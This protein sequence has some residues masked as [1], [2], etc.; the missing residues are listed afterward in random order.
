MTQ[1]PR[2][3]ADV[4]EDRVHHERR[5]RPDPRRLRAAAATAAAAAAAT[6][7]L[8]RPRLEA[9]DEVLPEEGERV[10]WSRT[11]KKGQKL[12]EGRRRSR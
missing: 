3:A 10:L 5:Q 8:P 9:L 4:S 12:D 11:Q 2:T 6:L 7:V 1:G